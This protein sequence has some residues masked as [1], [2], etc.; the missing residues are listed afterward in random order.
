MP[1]RNNTKL[2]PKEALLDSLRT[3]IQAHDGIFMELNYRDIVVLSYLLDLAPIHQLLRIKRGNSTWHNDHMSIV[4]LKSK[5]DQAVGK[6][7][8]KYALIA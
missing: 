6:I 3:D 7:D 2:D 4:Q 1:A 8:D 5:L